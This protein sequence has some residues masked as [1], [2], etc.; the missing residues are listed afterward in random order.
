MWVGVGLHAGFFNLVFLHKID[1][2]NQIL[3][4]FYV[5]QLVI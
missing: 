5:M 1:P 2:Y 3:G 4:A